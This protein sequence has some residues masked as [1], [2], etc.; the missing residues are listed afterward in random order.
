MSQTLSKDVP[1]FYI[2][3]SLVNGFF[4]AFLFLPIVLFLKTQPWIYF[5]DQNSPSESLS[6]IALILLFAFVTGLPGLLVHDYVTGNNGPI[7]VLKRIY[8]GKTWLF[9]K[10]KGE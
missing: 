8:E 9:K 3:Y 7:A 6:S 1:S 10:S 5:L 2:I 4:F